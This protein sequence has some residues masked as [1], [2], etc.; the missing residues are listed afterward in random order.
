MSQSHGMTV[1]Y[2]TIG[3]VSSACKNLLK[4][5]RAYIINLI[6]AQNIHGSA[7]YGRLHIVIVSLNNLWDWGVLETDCTFAP[8]PQN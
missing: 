7:Q 5:R 3:V 6:N 1:S 4:M 2:K 8:G